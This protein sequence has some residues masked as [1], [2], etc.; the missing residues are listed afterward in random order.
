MNP[1]VA[2]AE[3]YSLTRD[4]TDGGN[5]ATGLI[6]LVKSGVIYSNQAGGLACRHPAEE[7]VFIPLQAF[8]DVDVDKL[9]C[10]LAKV[11]S[12]KYGDWCCNGI[13][14]EDADYLDKVFEECNLPLRVDRERLKD[15]MEAWLYVI[16]TRDVACDVVKH[17]VGFK[18]RRAVLTWLNSD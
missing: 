10:G 5:G 9:E 14:E 12:E 1:S 3:G 15:S 16:I 6:V 8:P 17:L 4:A 18:G 2:D 11:F 13:D 7:G